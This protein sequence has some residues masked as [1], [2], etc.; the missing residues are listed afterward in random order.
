MDQRPRT[1]AAHTVA[2]A[3]LGR[4]E[5]R[6]KGHLGARWGAWF[7][8]LTISPQEDGTTVLH[9]PV[10]DQAALFGVLQ[11]LRDLALPLISVIY[12]DPDIPSATPTSARSQS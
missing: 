8:R 5:I 10:A 6:V 3:A 9:G 11:G 1:D 7:D 12:V 2:P 4:V